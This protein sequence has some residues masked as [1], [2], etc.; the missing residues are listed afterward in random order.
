MNAKSPSA[1]SGRA[2]H[3]GNRQMVWKVYY[4]DKGG[5]TERI[6]IE[7]TDRS[8]VFK[9][10]SARKM[11]P[12]RV[13]AVSAQAKVRRSYPRYITWVGVAAILTIAMTIVAILLMRGDGED[14][15][16]ITSLPSKKINKP[17]I[18]TI[19]QRVAVSNDAAS[20]QTTAKKDAGNKP[21][22]QRFG[23]YE[24]EVDENGE[25]WIYRD[26]K[27]RHVMSLSPGTT[28]QLF[29]NRA[30]N[31]LSAILTAKPGEAIVGFDFDGRRFKSDFAESLKASIEFSDDDTP[32]EREEK[33]IVI[34][35]K[36]KLLQY[37]KEGLDIAEI[38]R[39]EY[40]EVA[41]LNAMKTDLAAEIAKMRREG[42]SS[43][44]IEIQVAASNELLKQYGVSHEFKLL[45]RERIALEYSK[46]QRRN[47]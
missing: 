34:E 38:V 32:E 43:E 37:Q 9:I 35:A 30:E 2:F 25:R 15:G 46:H 44:E 18:Q 47:R 26:G 3:H 36:Q 20:A 13:D 16:I 40:R 23:K 27:R 28:R 39:N 1:V 31:Q 22:P 21:V 17:Q 12:I 8:E 6:E 10:L 19:S 14:T 45:R 29:F 11:S 41:K 4:R 42:A 24:V 7:A 5:K 33:E